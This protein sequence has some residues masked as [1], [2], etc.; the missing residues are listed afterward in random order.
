MGPVDPGNR[1][2]GGVSVTHPPPK[3]ASLPPSFL[4]GSLWSET[5]MVASLLNKRRVYIRP[6]REGSPAKPGIVQRRIDVALAP[7][8]AGCTGSAT[9]M[10]IG[11]SKGWLCGLQSGRRQVRLAHPRS[12][13]RLSASSSSVWGFLSRGHLIH[14][15]AIRCNSGQPAFSPLSTL[16]SGVSSAERCYEP[17]AFPYGPN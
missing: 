11:T 16:K 6:W 1:Y 5:N 10:M 12:G 14:L 4:P 3:R 8:D 15:I 7:G 13:S 9:S 2:Y 17:S